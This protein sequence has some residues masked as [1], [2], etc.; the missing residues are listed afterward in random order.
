MHGERATRTPGVPRRRVYGRNNK[1]REKVSIGP[2][3]EFGE[4]AFRGTARVPERGKA[5]LTKPDP[6]E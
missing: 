5:E 2:G 6:N 3:D 4:Q 1:G